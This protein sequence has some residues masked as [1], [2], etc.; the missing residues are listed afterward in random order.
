MKIRTLVIMLLS[1]LILIT[2]NFAVAADQPQVISSI[3]ADG[4]LTADPWTLCIEFTFN[5]SM[6]GSGYWRYSSTFLDGGSS[7]WSADMKTFRYYRSNINSP[8]PLGSYWFKLNPAG[9]PDFKSAATRTA[10]PETTIHFTVT[11]DGSNDLN[12]DNTAPQITGST[13]GDSAVNIDPNTDRLII[14]FSETMNFT[15]IDTFNSWTISNNSWGNLNTYSAA[16]DSKSLVIV[17]NSVNPLAAGDYVFTLNP[18]NN[19]HIPFADQ[20][21]NPLAETTI[22]FSVSTLPDSDY[23]YYIPYF[24]SGN[25]FWSGVGIANNNELDAASISIMLYNSDGSLLSSDPPHLIPADGQFVGTLADGETA[26]GWVKIISYNQLSGLCF[27]GSTLMADIP[28]VSELSRKL[29]IPHVAQDNLW[30]TTIMVCNPD[31]MPVQLKIEYMPQAGTGS[32]SYATQSLPP[33]GSAVYEMETIFSASLPLSSGKIKL[34]SLQG[35]G[36][37]AFALY[38]NQKSGGSNYAGVTAVPLPSP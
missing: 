16:M 32:I 33:L 28:F 22:T 7:E 38:T 26:T 19:P 2:F 37:A 17:R 6:T 10:L 21:G 4:D 31:N 30:N 12:P 20:A 3:P 9:H 36:I 15:D 35:N 34:I 23:S 14:T 11:A 1:T 13:P 24:K 25:N 27:M 8:I 5:E 18:A 29:V